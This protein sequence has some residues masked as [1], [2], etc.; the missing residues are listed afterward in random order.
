MP[1]FL[2]AAVP[3]ALREV[4]TWDAD[5][6]IKEAEECADVIA[7]G[8]DA[9]F[10]ATV[11]RGDVTGDQAREALA[12]GLAILACRAE[13]VSFAGL[14]WSVEGCT[15]AWNLPESVL[16]REARGAFFT[17]RE[18]AEEITSRTLG[19]LVDSKPDASDITVF[20]VADIACG[21]GA[22]LLA[23]ARFLASALL[24]SWD[25]DTRD[26]MIDLYGDSEAAARAEVID[27]CIHGVDLD[28]LSVELA[29]VALQLL[30]PDEDS[31][32][33]DRS[34]RVGDTLV[35]EI[36]PGDTEPF[37]PGVERFDWHREFPHVFPGGFDAILGNPPY[38][39]GQKITGTFGVPYREHLVNHVADGVR[40]SADL[41]AYFVIRACDLCREEGTV[42]VITT[43]TL[44]QGVTGRVAGLV[45]ERGWQVYARRE[46]RWPTRSAAV[47]CVLVWLHYKRW[48]AP[49]WSLSPIDPFED[50][51]GG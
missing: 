4:S 1:D 29:K 12:R 30:V 5:R 27:G 43:N 2:A 41:C 35:G 39:G 14:N 20:R 38:L 24:D 34:I 18:L 17:P 28:P 46:Q 7:G 45:R 49:G 13:G 10:A 31:I 22:F 16:T 19:P 9:L 50:S 48:I 51:F 40:G 47:E 8:A 36:L 21:S 23:A 6:R 33:L 3:S 11:K 26:E 15:G 44:G 37:P 25:D 42:G 32:S